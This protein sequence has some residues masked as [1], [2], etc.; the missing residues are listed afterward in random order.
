MVRGNTTQNWSNIFRW[1]NQ[2]WF[3]LPHG[4]YLLPPP[5]HQRGVSVYLC[6]NSVPLLVESICEFPRLHCS[7]LLNFHLPY[8]V[9]WGLFLIAISI[10]EMVVWGYQKPTIASTSEDSGPG[11]KLTLGGKFNSAVR[12]R[13]RGLLWWNIFM[14]CSTFLKFTNCIPWKNTYFMM[15]T[16]YLGLMMYHDISVMSYLVFVVMSYVY[17]IHVHVVWR[18]SNS[19]PCCRL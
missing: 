1:D 7:T 11:K 9:F 8:W 5:H 19:R 13:H 14:V 4:L 2:F 16:L 10:L 18:V 6:I 12:S 3:L 15:L 17:Y